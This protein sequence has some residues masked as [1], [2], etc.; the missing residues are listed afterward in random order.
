M[1]ATT[2]IHEKYWEKWCR[3]AEKVKIDWLLQDVQPLIR[4]YSKGCQICVQGVSGALLAISKTLELAGLNSPVCRAYN[5][6]IL[7]IERCIKGWWREDPPLVPQLALPVA[8]VDR[9]ASQ[10]YDTSTK[11]YCPLDQAVANLAQ[12]AFSF[13]FL[14]GENT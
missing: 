4:F 1:A 2:R 9:L 13:L 14:V 12:L 6:Y 8:T 5:K 10:A 3:Y 7:P 11:D